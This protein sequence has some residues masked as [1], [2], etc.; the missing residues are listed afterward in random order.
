[1]ERIYK[2]TNQYDFDITL[3]PVDNKPD[4]LE[5]IADVLY[6]A[7]CDDALVSTTCEYG[8]YMIT[9]DFSRVAKN[10]FLA[11]QSACEDIQSAKIPAKFV[12]LGWHKDQECGTDPEC[13]FACFTMMTRRYN[14]NLTPPMDFL[15]RPLGR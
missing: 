6:E 5:D 15:G 3:S 12:T 13:I 10:E 4:I 1:M 11:V 8:N 9:V 7:G 14:A 2:M